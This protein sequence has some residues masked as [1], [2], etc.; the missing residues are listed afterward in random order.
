MAVYIKLPKQQEL[1]LIAKAMTIDTVINKFQI[2]D[3]GLYCC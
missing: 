2:T 3:L 1:L